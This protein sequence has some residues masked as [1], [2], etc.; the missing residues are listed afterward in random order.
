MS[1][2][3]ALILSAVPVDDTL[4]K[5]F[6]WRTTRMV[7]HRTMLRSTSY[8]FGTK[9]LNR[10]YKIMYNAKRLWEE[11]EGRKCDPGYL[12]IRVLTEKE[13]NNSR[14]FRP[15]PDDQRAGDY[16]GRYFRG[17]KTL[18]ITHYGLIFNS[19]NFAHEYSHHLNWACDVF[20]IN[21]D[22]EHE[23]ID[24]FEDYYL[25]NVK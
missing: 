17:A 19:V 6:D 3:F 13:M 7:D 4:V 10:V 21:D 2:W 24:E 14:H 5:P 9:K 18:Y 11:F 16:Y 15:S 23:R 12:E 20:Y 8:K 22:A 25:R 1:L